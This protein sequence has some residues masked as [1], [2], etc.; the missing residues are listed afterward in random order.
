MSI[1]MYSGV[2]GTEPHVN[3]VHKVLIVDDMLFQIE[4]M[5]AVLEE[6]GYDVSVALGGE[7]AIERVKTDKPDIVLLDLLMP[8]MNGFEVLRSLQHDAN[9][10]VANTPV[11]VISACG[12]DDNVVRALDFGAQDYVT[13]P[14]IPPL[15]LAR[16]RSVLRLKCNR[17]HL[18]VTNRQLSRIASLDPLTEMFNRR[19]FYKLAEKERI[20]AKLCQESLSAIMLDIDHFKVLNDRHGHAMGDESLRSLKAIFQRCIRKSD[21]AGR[22]GGDEFAIIC[23][24]TDL[25]SAVCLAERIRKG[26]ESQTIQLEEVKAKMTISLGVASQEIGDLTI[27]DMLKRADQM[28]YKAKGDGHNR[29]VQYQSP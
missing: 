9:Y 25:S 18:L 22:L 3:R 26:V 4:L 2:R 6:N 16:L 27:D 7:E 14:I 19:W 13:K 20:K 28:L 10:E 21:I 29:V 11:I 17:D 1:N 5:K 15:L 24:N 8:K 12:D 23:P